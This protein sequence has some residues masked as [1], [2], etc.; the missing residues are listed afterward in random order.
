[1]KEVSISIIT[2]TYNA[3]KYLPRLV[4]SLEKQRDKNFEWVVADGASTDRTLEILENAKRSLKNVVVDSRP[5][6]G[7]YD[8]LNRAIKI[9]KGDYY[10]VV[11]ADDIL[12]PDAIENYRKA[13]KQSNADLITARIKIGNSIRGPKRPAWGW[14][15]G[16]SAYVSGHVVGL[17]IRKD[18][19]EKFGYYSRRFPI[20]AVNS[21]F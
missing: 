9:S 6:F 13:A 12:F 21:L 11:G 2:A 10:L 5:D 19:H 17:L 20:A 14:L 8:V 16:Q 3:E 4:E 1:M 15:Y 18:L 7:I